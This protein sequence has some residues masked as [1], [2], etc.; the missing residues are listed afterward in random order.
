VSRGRGQENLEVRLYRWL[1]V[2]YPVE[3]REEYV[4]EM[5]LC[6]QNAR[7]DCHGG[8]GDRIS[9]WIAMLSDLFRSAIKENWQKTFRLMNPKPNPSRSIARFIK[10]Y[11]FGTGAV[12][13]SLAEVMGL[14]IRMRYF[15]FTESGYL[16]VMAQIIILSLV[17]LICGF[18]LDIEVICLRRLRREVLVGSLLLNVAGIGVMVAAIYQVQH[19]DMTIEEMLPVILQIT[20]CGTIWCQLIALN[21]VRILYPKVRALG[22]FASA[23]AGSMRD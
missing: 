21:D 17:I 5:L 10:S 6:F 3:F 12:V 8:I 11:P 15:D 13:L 9:F 19:F 1:L 18:I 23:E 4:D 22:P 14:G 16:L 2:L 20:T 7:R